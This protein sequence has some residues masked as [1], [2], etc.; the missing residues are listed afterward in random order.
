MVIITSV[1]AMLVSLDEESKLSSLRGNTMLC[2][3]GDVFSIFR[4]Y[5]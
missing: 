5:V 3:I 2:L 4:D 1:L